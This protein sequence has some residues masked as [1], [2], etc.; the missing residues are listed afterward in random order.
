MLGSLFQTLNHTDAEVSYAPKHT[1]GLKK[2]KEK[3]TCSQ[4]TVT[5]RNLASLAQVCAYGPHESGRTR[6]MSQ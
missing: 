3:K 6:G 4:E 1:A 2:K 5:H